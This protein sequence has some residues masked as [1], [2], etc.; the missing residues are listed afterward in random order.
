MVVIWGYDIIKFLIV[1][2]IM[3]LYTINPWVFLFLDM[4]TVPTYVIGWNC[5]ISSLAGEI[6]TFRTLFKWSVITFVSSTVP[7]FYAAWAG[8]QT[9]PKQAW[10]VLLL[11]LIFLIVNLIRKIFQ[12]KKNKLIMDIK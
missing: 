6:K 12:N 2:K 8:R 9:F 5:L 7:Y 1:F 11:I 10:L 4:V 3:R